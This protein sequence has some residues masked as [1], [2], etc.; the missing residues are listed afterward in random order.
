VSGFRVVTGGRIDRARPLAFRYGGRRLVG[1]AGD[2]LASALVA[3]GVVVAGRSF[4]YHRPRGVFAAGVEEPNVVVTLGTGATAVPNLRAIEIELFSGLEARPVNC[5]PGAGFDLGALAGA[6]AALLPA[7]FYY[8]TFKWPDS[9]WRRVYEPA[10]RRM[11]GLGR[12]PR[13]P[14]PD[15]YAQRHAHVGVLVVGGGRA[16]LE[17]ARAAAAAGETVLLADE[18]AEFGGK[19]IGRADAAAAPGQAWIDAAVAALAARP[20]ATLLPRT[21]ALGL[22]DQGYAVLV[23][24]LTDHLPERER[25]GPRQRLWLV[26]AGRVILATGAHERPLIYPGND[27]PGTMLAGAAHTFLRRYAAAAG[28]RVVV[29]TD[30]DSAYAVALALAESGV[31]VPAIVDARADPPPTLAAAAERAGIPVRAGWRLVRAVGGQRVRAVEAAPADDPEG[32]EVFGA[33]AVAVSG[34]WSPALHLWSQAQGRLD[35]SEALQGYVPG[36][37]PA[38]CPVAV[39]GSASG[40]GLPAAMPIAPPMARG[41]A[42]VDLQNDVTAADIA[43]AAREG[44]VSVEHLK[45]YTTAGMATDQGKTANVAAIALLAAATGRAPQA[46]GHTTF[47]PPYTPV[48]F[49]ALAGPERG[50]L[51]DPVRATPMQRQH[52]AAGAVF[53]NVGQWRRPLYFPRAGEGMDAAVAR[54]V[55]TTRRAAG[56]LDASTLGKFD[57]S[58][59]DAARFLDRLYTNRMSTLAPGRCRYGLMCRDDGMVFDDGVATRLG[60]A[61]FHVTTTSGGAERVHAWMEEWRQTEWPDL[62]VHVANVAEQWACA[63]IAGPE[64]AAI[65]AAVLPGLDTRAAAFPPMNFR[66]A[67]FAGR[68]ARVFRVSFTGEPSFEINVPADLGA[69]LWSA[70][71]EVGGPQGLEPIGTEAL[72]VLRAE[73]GFI[74]VGHETDGTVTPLDLGLDRLVA[75]DR[76][77]V[78]RRA[79]DR[80]DTRRPDRKQLV[81]LLPLDPALALEDGAALV[82]LDDA[83]AA[84]ARL[85]ADPVGQ[86]PVPMIGHV[87]SSHVSPNLGRRFAL[88]LVKGGRERIGDEIAACVG[89]GTAPVTIVAPRFLAP[90]GAGR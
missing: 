37:A 67:V 43:L 81:G 60:P 69:R 85:A 80:P 9:W 30:N 72:H 58:G 78:G 57:V 24:R 39:A 40:A 1:Y 55:R 20:N 25:P 59:P 32:V 16:G 86:A 56:L 47:R 76:D 6:F 89:R 77:F 33:D 62:R 12:A 27:L 73:L 3:N 84:A 75:L 46:V 38:N 51:S 79:L 26:R 61:R 23:E 11:A 83:E 68:V 48:S 31:S 49:G 63:A 52:E 70:L 5:W 21:T 35:W 17:A 74:A 22:Y 90:S 19:R 34:G 65:V 14:D 53:E 87:T 66:E 2:T 42:F 13:L 8:K 44:M 71:V 4:K 82:E 7:G 36:A 29:A 18:Q 10:I 45:R 54:E 15:R 50:A 64:A 88:A 28:R 41:K